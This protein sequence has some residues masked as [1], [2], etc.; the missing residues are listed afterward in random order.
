MESNSNCNYGIIDGKEEVQNLA[1]LM[2]KF[3]QKKIDALK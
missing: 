1:K 2:L 3:K